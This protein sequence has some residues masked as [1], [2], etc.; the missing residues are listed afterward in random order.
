MEKLEDYADFVK[1]RKKNRK[2]REHQDFFSNFVNTDIYNEFAKDIEK[3]GYATRNN[4][5]F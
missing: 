2:H 1:M 5:T 3:G 4:E